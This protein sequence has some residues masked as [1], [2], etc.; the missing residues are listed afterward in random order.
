MDSSANFDFIDRFLLE[1]FS[2][3][4]CPV[5]RR[6]E[7]KD[8][9]LWAQ[10]LWA[11]GYDIGIHFKKRSWYSHMI[12]IYYIFFI[13]VFLSIVFVFLP[14]LS[15]SLLMNV[16]EAKLWFF[17]ILLYPPMSSPYGSRAHC[18]YFVISFEIG[19]TGFMSTLKRTLLAPS[20]VLGRYNNSRVL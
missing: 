18:T 1:F 7:M 20:P 10:S 14:H 17:W 4:C 6:V 3:K 19:W 15:F 16:F 2:K 5:F 13:L 9:T 11:E 8:W 12:V